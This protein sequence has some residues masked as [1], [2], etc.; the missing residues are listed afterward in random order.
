LCYR[1]RRVFKYVQVWNSEGVLLLM[2]TTH[3]QK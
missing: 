2:I 3:T 1:Q